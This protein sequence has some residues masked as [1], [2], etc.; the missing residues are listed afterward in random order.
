MRKNTCVLTLPSRNL[1]S[2]SDNNGIYFNKLADEIIRYSKIRNYLFTPR[3]FLSFEHVNYKIN[4]NEIILLEEILFD[5]YL[6]DI[7]LRQDNRYIESTN[8]Y[9]IINP[10]NRIN[11]SSKLNED[12]FKSESESKDFESSIDCMRKK[13]QWKLTPKMRKNL[14]N[15]N[16]PFQIEQYEYENICGFQ[17]IQFV[18][19]N[20][21]G[22]NI[23]ISEIKT[24]LIEE[25][26]KLDMPENSLELN[27]MTVSTW[28]VF[29][30]VNWL[31]HNKL[32]AEEVISKPETKK[33][34]EITLQIQ[35]ELYAPTE[36]D[37]FL[38]LKAY[39]IPSII[40]MK[41]IEK[42]M[43]DVNVSIFNTF[44]ED[45]EQIYIILVGKKLKSAT[46]SFGI[47]K[48]ND[49]YRIPKSIINKKL[50]SGVRN[51]NKFIQDSL[52][53]QE[54]KKAKKKKQD[55]LAQANVRKK[56][57]KITL[58]SKN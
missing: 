26:L 1:Y 27:K 22:K 50:L 34:D 35:N 36:V 15:N 6:D 41:G 38:I 19:F 48:M 43:L 40:K 20:Y 53:F 13:N 58:S 52:I 10:V 23:G 32:A 42:T 12:V 46:R 18:L 14:S 33:N 44:D 9:D 4:D 2:N 5:T 8:I 57:G 31:N 29:S 7:K 55:R 39:N 25:Y 3:E 49:I 28:K 37:L 47:L 56:R 51:M 11:Y 24:K 16:T 30:Y 21:T 17:L 45:N 54:T